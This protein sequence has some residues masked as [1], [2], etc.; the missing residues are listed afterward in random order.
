[1]A[2]SSPS[3]FYP[4]T[5][6]CP[7]YPLQYRPLNSSPLVASPSGSP[8]M[9]SPV[10]AAQARR[11]SQYKAAVSVHP[12]RESSTARRLFS[13]GA[14]PTE[15]AD[16]QKA[17]LRS[18]FKARCFERAAKARERAVSGKRAGKM[19][20]PSSDDYLMDDDGEEEDEDIMQDEVGCPETM[21]GRRVLTLSCV[22]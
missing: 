3:P 18:R 19:R 4:S 16:P 2:S 13:S 9:S 21:R 1:M 8:K 7:R 17:F 10:V 11:R 15:S 20:E 6:A 5:P 14:E 22:P 12:E